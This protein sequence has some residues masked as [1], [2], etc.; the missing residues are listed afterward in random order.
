MTEAAKRIV[1]V[2][3]VLLLLYFL[4]GILGAAF[5][6]VHTEGGDEG[7]VRHGEATIEHVPGVALWRE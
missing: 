6:S 2:V 1:V 4:L 7:I 3:L 5:S